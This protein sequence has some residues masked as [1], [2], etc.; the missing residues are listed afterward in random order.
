MSRH[1]RLG[2]RS[3]TVSNDGKRPDKHD[4]GSDAAGGLP[5]GAGDQLGSWA[6]GCVVGLLGTFL[7][8]VV[9]KFSPRAEDV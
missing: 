2:P 4:G 1:L 8:Q 9:L 5:H 6:L 3:R 7:G